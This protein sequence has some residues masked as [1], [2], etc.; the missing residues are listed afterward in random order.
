MG[1][2]Q[3]SVLDH[4]SVLDRLC[5]SSEK[6]AEPSAGDCEASVSDRFFVLSTTRSLTTTDLFLNA[7]GALPRE[8]D[9]CVD[10][11]QGN[12][13]GRHGILRSDSNGSQPNILCLRLPLRQALSFREH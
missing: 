13:V 4:P 6:P 3:P 5:V 10:F 8:F 12:R 7:D 2:C 1:R 9:S 11:A